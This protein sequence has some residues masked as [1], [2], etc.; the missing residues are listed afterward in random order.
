MAKRPA[1][2]VDWILREGGVEQ[3]VPPAPRMTFDDEHWRASIE[4][5]EIDEG[6]RVYLT[7]A[8]IRRGVSLDAF[9]IVPGIW[10]CSKVAVKGRVTVSFADGAHFHLSPDRSLMFGPK[11]EQARFTQVPR[12]TLHL[13]GYMLRADRVASLCDDDMPAAIQPLIERE[14]DGTTIVAVTNSTSLR[15]IAAR[16]LSDQ[17]TGALR[18]VWLEGLT[19]QLFALQCMIGGATGRRAHTL[20]RAERAAIEEARERLLVDLRDPPGGAALAAAVGVSE[21]RLNAGFREIFGSTVF[22]TLRDERLEHAR[23]ALDAE[24]IPLK[25]V[26]ERIGYRHVTNFIRAYTARYGH[27]PR[28]AARNRGREPTNQI[29]DRSVD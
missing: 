27:A 25:V 28:E 8:E 26:A 16:M 10:L 11:D 1:R 17:F 4:R 14:P 15:R 19:L 24:Q 21:R 22:D 3:A 29:A 9:Q 2:T 7:H 12:Q 5:V 20:T 6:L 13:A 23:L 18:Q